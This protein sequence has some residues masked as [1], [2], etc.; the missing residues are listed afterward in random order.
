MAAGVLVV[1]GGL[2][3]SG[4]CAA[5]RGAGYDGP[6]T[7]VGAESCAPYDR[8]PL[9]KDVLVGGDPD[10]TLQPSLDELEVTVR[11][12]ERAVALDT[13]ARTV[14]TDRA[15]RSY[16]DLVIA[17]GAEPIALPGAGDQL[18]LRTRADAE[19][20]RAALVPG[21]RVVLVGAGWIGAEVATAALAR[22]CVVTCLE[23][24]PFP[25]AT[26]LGDRAG[27]RIAAWW[28]GID[29]RCDTAVRA[30]EPGGVVLEDGSWIDA[31]L[32]VTGVG[33]RPAVGWLAGSGL[34]LD[35]GVAVDADRRTS[36]PHVY[37]VGD[38]AARWSDRI[39]GRVHV[40]HWD[41]AA[42][43]PAAVAA[44]VL[45][46]PK[47]QDDVPYF[48]SDQFGR[49]IQYVGQH[50]DRCRPVLREGSDPDRWGVAWLD[51]DDRMTAH[52]SVS[53]P[54]ASALSRGL[55]ESGAVLDPALLAD[56]NARAVTA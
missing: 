30:V 45:G 37:A 39:G 6:I 1:G 34:E 15:E 11:L 28:D 10:I 31:D 48:W 13:A 36:D 20:L 55:I 3:G 44:A 5:L 14:H 40:G 50:T 54:R 9:S 27:A 56:L 17:T 23:L 21:A 32:V 33:V 2:G 22:G 38:A 41:E 52:L 18:L 24:D 7:L 43:G 42:T 53:S 47:G 51:D 12:G 4:T 25:L 49:K 35:G 8:P 16:D 19:R 29:L 46:T 26:P